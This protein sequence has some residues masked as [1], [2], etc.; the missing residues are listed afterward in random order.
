MGNSNQIRWKWWCYYWRT[1]YVEQAGKIL[2]KTTW[3]MGFISIYFL[4][5]FLM[6][7]FFSY[8]AQLLQPGEKRPMEDWEPVTYLCIFLF[9][10]L[11]GYKHIVLC[12]AEIWFWFR[13]FSFF[14]LFSPA[15]ITWCTIRDKLRR[16]GPESRSNIVGHKEH[17]T[18]ETKRRTNILLL[19]V[20]VWN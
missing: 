1:S 10:L 19:P 14:F 20:F 9:L 3:I 16:S 6:F 7:C 13:F 8:D 15:A 18:K 5:C 17:W 11:L 12:S 4:R 2:F